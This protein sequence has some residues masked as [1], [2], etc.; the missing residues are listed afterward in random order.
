MNEYNQAYCPK[1]NP[2]RK[3]VDDLYEEHYGKAQKAAQG[4]GIGALGGFNIP[5]P[6][7][8]TVQTYLEGL[9]ALVNSLFNE[10]VALEN[11]L[12][13][14]LQVSKCGENSQEPQRPSLCETDKTIIK[15]ETDIRSIGRRIKDLQDSF[16]G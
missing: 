6:T 14:Y 9:V 10:V 4:L 2:A 11:R 1:Q 12:G 15:L 16:V 7:K 5:Q 13:N 3:S 8:E